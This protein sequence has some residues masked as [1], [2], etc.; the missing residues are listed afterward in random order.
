MPGNIN[1][2]CIP[3][4]DNHK[5][6]KSG[7]MHSFAMNIFCQAYHVNICTY[8]MQKL[9]RYVWVAGAQ[10]LVVSVSGILLPT[11]QR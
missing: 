2:I 11:L 7:L 1:L 4:S 9:K 8:L 3:S 5:A 10:E 6:C